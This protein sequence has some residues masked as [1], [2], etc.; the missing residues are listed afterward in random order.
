MKSHL[1]QKY[2][3]DTMIRYRNLLDVMDTFL[4]VHEASNEMDAF[5]LIQT[6]VTLLK[7]T[8]DN[9]IEQDTAFSNVKSCP[10]TIEDS[11]V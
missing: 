6:Q 3:K 11:Y 2:I 1:G 10:Y 8:I 9:W 4:R 7:A 5:Y